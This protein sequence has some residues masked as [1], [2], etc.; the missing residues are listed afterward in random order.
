MHIKKQHHNLLIKKQKL[1]VFMEKAKAYN[2]EKFLWL[3][4]CEVL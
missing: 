3:T 4:K 1:Y 2:L